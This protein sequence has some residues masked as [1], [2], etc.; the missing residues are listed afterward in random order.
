[1]TSFYYSYQNPWVFLCLLV[2][3][4]AF[5]LLSSAELANLHTKAKTKW[6]LVIVVKYR[7]RAIVLL[8]GLNNHVFKRHTS[9]GS[10]RFAILGRAFEH[11][12]GQI[13][14]HVIWKANRTH[15]RLTCVAKKRLCWNSLIPPPPSSPHPSPPK[16]W[17]PAPGDEAAKIEQA[18]E[19]LRGRMRLKNAN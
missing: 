18:K 4:K 13:E 8:G 7:H 2:Q 15:F 10:G 16:K 11:I 17:S 3:I 9:I 5:V 19:R 1:M 14:R 6:I 12:F